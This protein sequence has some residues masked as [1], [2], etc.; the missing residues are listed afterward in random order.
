MKGQIM[1][2]TEYPSKIESN[3]KALA[4]LTNEILEARDQMRDLEIDAASEVLE[5]RNG[6]GKALYTNDKAREIATHKILKENGHREAVKQLRQLEHSRAMVEAE[7]ERL[8][9]E[10]RIAMIDYEREQLGQRAA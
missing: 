3:V 2:I 6:D 5:A 1:N 10:Q 4:T 8:R 7:L 9:R